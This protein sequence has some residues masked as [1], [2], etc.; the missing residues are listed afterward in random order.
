MWPSPSTNGL[1]DTE[2]HKDHRHQQDAKDGSHQ[3]CKGK[4][5]YLVEAQ[6]S[7]IYPTATHTEGTYYT[8]CQEVAMNGH[9][10]KSPHRYGKVSV[11]ILHPALC[12]GKNR[13]GRRH[14]RKQH[15]ELLLRD[16]SGG[17]GSPRAQQRE[18]PEARTSPARAQADEHRGEPMHAGPGR[19]QRNWLPTEFIFVCRICAQHRHVCVQVYTPVHP[20]AGPT[21]DIRSLPPLLHDLMPSERISHG[22]RGLLFPSGLA[23]Q[24]ESSLSCAPLYVGVRD[25]NSG[26]RACRLSTLTEASS[27]PNPH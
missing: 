8:G 22:T 2:R 16:N 20:C 19:Q 5:S 4:T 12:R 25:L 3:H 18:G 10:F 13:E 14:L 24:P 15:T 7:T 23:G 1:V 11:S 17:Q 21:Q 6:G 9:S 26:P 27:R